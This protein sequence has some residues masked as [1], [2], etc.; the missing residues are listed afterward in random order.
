MVG[1]LLALAHALAWL[2]Y[3]LGVLLQTLPIPRKSLKAWGP[4]L[5]MDAVIA[6]F[7]LTTVGMVESL[8][9]WLSSL[10]NS[11]IG[12][13]LN[14]L[15]SFSLILGE[16]AAFETALLTIM[17]LVA[18]HAEALPLLPVLSNILNPALT[19]ATVALTTWIIIQ[20]IASLL[21]SIWFSTYALG[22]AFYAIP[23]RVGRRLGSYLIA[24]STVLTIALPIMPSLALSLQSFL[25]YELLVKP[26]QDAVLT[27]DPLMVIDLLLILSTA[28]PRILAAMVISLI[29]FPPVYLFM[30]SALVRGVANS[31]GGAASGP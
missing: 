1:E 8:V 17:G 20:A 3:V 25:G 19:I 28:V 6:E 23:F 24:C 4:T 21:P 12:S 27:F 9:K 29:I 5:M 10:L 26:V 15:A 18:S 16:L 7:S 22:L 11:S 2:S 14:P 31:I 13:P 30:V